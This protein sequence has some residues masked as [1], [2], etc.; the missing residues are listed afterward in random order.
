MIDETLYMYVSLYV[1]GEGFVLN[2]NHY[3]MEQCHHNQIEY[4]STVYVKSYC[5]KYIH[6]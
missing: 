5:K 2:E 3:K 1:E 4:K 6:T